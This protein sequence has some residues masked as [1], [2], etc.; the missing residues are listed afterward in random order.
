M[1]RDREP[2]YHFVA[3]CVLSL[4]LLVAFSLYKPFLT[5]LIIAFLLTYLLDPL[6]KRLERKT[7]LSRTFW[8]L[9][10]VF[11]LIFTIGLLVLLL[12]P[13]LLSQLEELGKRLPDYVTALNS[14]L[15][16]LFRRLNQKFH[17]N[18]QAHFNLSQELQVQTGGLFS[19]LST[20]AASLF[21]N[22][23]LFIFF[24]ISLILVPLFT[25]YLLKELPKIKTFFIGILPPSARLSLLKKAHELNLVVGAFLRGQL[26]IS[27]ILALLYSLGLTIIG[28]PFAALLGVFAGLGDIVPYFGTLV[29]FLAAVALC[30]LYALPWTTLLLLVLVFTGVKLFENWFLY[31]RIMGKKIGVHPLIIILTLL[32]AGRYFGFIGLLLAVPYAGACKLFLSDLIKWYRERYLPGG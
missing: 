15:S 5:P 13:L 14:S 29:G 2:V 19:S 10:L 21:T 1:Y 23:S 24:L 31:P 17:L 9:T 6:V 7:N 12:T 32:L 8:S 30:L 4:F 3:F 28:V 18:W 22:I 27:L 20:F 25:F 11:L 26:I 16:S